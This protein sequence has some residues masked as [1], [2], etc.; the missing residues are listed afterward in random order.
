M[1]IRDL[2]TN[3]QNNFIDPLGKETER[4]DKSKCLRRFCHQLDVEQIV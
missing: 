3:K 4:N 1:G 2:Q